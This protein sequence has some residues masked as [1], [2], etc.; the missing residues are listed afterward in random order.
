[1]NDYHLIIRVCTFLLN[2][3]FVLV[4]MFEKVQLNEFIKIKGINQFWKNNE[5]TPNITKIILYTNRLTRIS[6]RLKNNKSSVIDSLK[7]KNIPNNLLVV[8]YIV[9]N[10]YSSVLY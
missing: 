5:P 2:R 4:D 7:I 8:S 10:V 3:L 6:N 1:M 9:T